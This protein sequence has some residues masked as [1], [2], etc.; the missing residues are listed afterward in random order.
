ML[1]LVEV[2]NVCPRMARINANKNKA[3]QNYLH[4]RSFAGDKLT[5]THI[6]SEMSDL[7][8]PDECYKIIGGC[9]EVYNEKGCGFLESVYQECMEIEYD[10][11]HIPFV[12]QETLR[13]SY[14]GKELKHRFVPDFICFGKIIVEIKAVD[15][16]TDKHRAQVI[17]YLNA[18][19]YPLG[20]LVNFGGHP[21]IEWERLVLTNKKTR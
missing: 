17:N 19:G 3:N 5:T 9:F 6:G 2:A 10:F 14:R 21:K 15:G 7:I 4:W 8:Y 18:T 1:R 11:Q 13:L 16:L 12:A 20:L